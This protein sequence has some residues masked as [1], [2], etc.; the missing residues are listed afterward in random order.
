MVVTVDG[1]EIHDHAWMRPQQ[2]MDR[3]N[4]REI[5]LSPP[6]WI[7]L[8][9]LARHATVAEALDALASRA[10][11]HFATR[12]AVEGDAVVALYAGDAAYD[13]GDLGVDGPRHRL[14]MSD[15][16]WRYER[17]GWIS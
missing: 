17:D 3:R 10:P 9:E 6:T 7:T 11:E 15:G 14:W 4:A 12:I 2:A 1:G 5:E 13:T 16:D 8:E